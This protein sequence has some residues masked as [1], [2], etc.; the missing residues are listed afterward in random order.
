LPEWQQKDLLAY[1]R[2]MLGLYV[3]S[4]PLSGLESQ[5][6]RHSDTTALSI[7]ELNVEDGATVNI[8]GLITQV[9]HKVARNSGNQYALMVVEDNTGEV[10]VT[11]MRK[12]YQAL[13]ETLYPDQIITLR[14]RISKRDDRVSVQAIELNTLEVARESGGLVKIQIREQFA[15]KD[16]IAELNEL[17]VRYPGEV[18]VQLTLSLGTPQHFMLPHRVRVVPELF[19]EIKSMFGADAVK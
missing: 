16:R 11:V 13:R 12:V 7:L 10:E 3:S 2:E 5:L 6:S 15:T 14:G 17:L 4:H 1:E 9:Q 8:A 18:E 19:G